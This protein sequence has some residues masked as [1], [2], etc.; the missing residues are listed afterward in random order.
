M[1]SLS[2]DRRIAGM[3]VTVG[4]RPG[5]DNR[6]QRRWS[7]Y[8]MLA[9]GPVLVLAAC[10]STTD[11][12]E[13]QDFSQIQS[14]DFEFTT[15]ANGV[16]RMNVTTNLDAACSIAY[17]ET[18][19]LGTVGTD[20]DMGGGAHAKHE[21][22]LINA[23]PGKTYSFRVQGADASGTLY[24]STVSTFTAPELPEES[25]DAMDG[26]GENLAL[27]AT[28]LDVSSVFSDSWSGENA[29]DGDI[30]TEWATKGS[31][32]DAYIV[33]DLGSSQQ[34]TGVEFITRTMS[35]G[36]A[37][38]TEFTV[39]VDD[40]DTYGPFP[41]GDQDDPRFVVVD[42]SGQVLRFDVA[43]STGGNT[44]AIEIRAFAGMSG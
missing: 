22:V 36:T 34:I 37:T 10:S 9:V 30:N 24:Q 15:D 38:T 27:G 23:E 2:S 4:I 25:D 33:I 5:R 6:M 29:V 32:D 42:F 1:V 35:D 31:G 7:T 19:A 43:V 14:S 17:G 39:T 12:G 21:V 8:V 28:V 41:A 40:G 13:I 26:H 3:A 11:V 44:G 18:D 16:V 20:D